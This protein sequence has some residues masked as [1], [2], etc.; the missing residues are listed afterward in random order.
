MNRLLQHFVDS[1]A[2]PRPHSSLPAPPQ[3]SKGAS[4]TSQRGSYHR[5]NPGRPFYYQPPLQ[6]TSGLVDIPLTSDSSGATYETVDLNAENRQEHWSHNGSSHREETRSKALSSASD[7]FSSPTSPL[8]TDKAS[9]TTDTKTDLNDPFAVQET[10]SSVD[11]FATST[12]SSHSN[13]P[14]AADA[15]DVYQCADVLFTS[16]VPQD[17]SKWVQSPPHRRQPPTQAQEIFAHTQTST[18]VSSQNG[19]STSTPISSPLN[20]D[21]MQGTPSLGT[22]QGTPSPGTMQGTPFS[23]TLQS[24]PS[25]GTLSVPPSPVPAS[26]HTS[27]SFPSTHRRKSSFK[28]PFDPRYPK[29]PLAKRDEDVVSTAPSVALSRHSRLSTLDDSLKLSELYHHMVA[30]LEK[31]KHEL[32]QVVA[33][34]AHEIRQLQHQKHA[35]EVQVTKSHDRD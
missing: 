30:R 6:P 29:Y 14:S 21:T 31:E 35:L 11:F 9:R 8:P 10:C 3:S 23:G 25:P 22:N 12:R 17:D 4:V 1:P 2:S 26:P 20:S 27:A 13:P 18:S 28:S 24:T 7:L 32:L 5:T 16:S 33:Q 15:K 34:Q 19:A